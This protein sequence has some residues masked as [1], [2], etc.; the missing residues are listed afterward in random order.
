VRLILA[1][2]VVREVGEIHE[3]EHALLLQLGVLRPFHE[4]DDRV[5]LGL[6]RAGSPL[7][8]SKVAS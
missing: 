4:V 3:G 2:G 1:A 7:S 5:R 6:G 8:P